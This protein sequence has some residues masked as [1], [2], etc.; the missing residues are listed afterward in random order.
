MV[1]S[2]ER[3]AVVKATLSGDVA[4][5]RHDALR[6]VLTNRTDVLRYL[7]FLLGD[8]AYATLL[9]QGTGENGGFQPDPAY[10]IDL[11][12][13]EPLVR[14]VARDDDSLE[15]I[16]NLIRDLRAMENGDELVPDGFQDIWDAVWEC[17]REGTR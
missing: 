12:L 14:A 15:R 3:T 16:A 10:A 9:G 11:A 6:E 17:Y 2:C 8:P 7:I 4:G 5:R 1:G 13:F